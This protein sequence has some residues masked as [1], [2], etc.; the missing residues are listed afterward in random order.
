M[1][2]VM[3][4]AVVVLL[5]LGVRSVR[6]DQTTGQ[7]PAVLPVLPAAPPVSYQV[8]PAPPTKVV[9][10]PPPITCTGNDYAPV[11]SYKPLVPV[12]A[13]PPQYYLGR[14]LFGSPKLYVPRQPI[15]NFLRYLTF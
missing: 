8:E 7:L 1:K 11:V 15:R 9:L 5:A 3:E 10:P 6:A 13:P 2:A 4:I 14:G 12:T